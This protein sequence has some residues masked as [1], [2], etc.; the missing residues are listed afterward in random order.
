VPPVAVE[1]F[2]LQSEGTAVWAFGDG[3]HEAEYDQRTRRPFRWSGR[4]ADLLVVNADNDTEITLVADSPM[5]YFAEP[6]KVTIAAG[7]QVLRSE[8]A[9]ASFSWRI[10]VPLDALNR[11]SG[12]VTISTD[13]AFRPSESGVAD[14]RE[15]GLRFFAV[16]GSR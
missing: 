7:G 2:D 12:I 8:Q 11:A 13:R 9:D 14:G 1:Q 5:K 16:A 15:L 10:R 4:R 6:P 3:W